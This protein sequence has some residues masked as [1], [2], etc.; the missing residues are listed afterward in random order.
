M[1]EYDSDIEFDFFDEPE[2][3]ES[4]ASPERPRSQRP[5]GGPPARRPPGHAGIP[6][7]AR[8]VG[9][10]AFGILII[11][12]LVLWVQS[13]SGTSRKSSYQRYLGK[14]ALLAADS[15]RFGSSLTQAIATPGIKAGE[16]ANKIDG[17]AQQQ[18][19]DV[20]VAGRLKAP[21]SLARPQ[22]SLLEA[23]RFRVAGL[24][25]LADALR[26]NAGSTNVPS[27]AVT[28]ASE[29]QRLVASDVIWE[30][31]FRRE[32]T[33]LM[34]RQQVTGLAAPSSRFLTDTGVDSTTFWTP[35]LERLNGAGRTG[36]NT[37]GNAV[38]TKLIGVTAQPG[39]KQLSTTT[40]TT[41][42]AGTNL[43]FDVSVQNSGDV[44]VVSV[45][46]TITIQQAPTPI[47]ATRTIALINPGETKTAAFKN[48]PSVNFVPQTKLN[49]DVK[50]VAR[51][52]N[53]NNNSA[54]YP[55]IF[56]LTGP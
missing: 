1:S 47:T 9:L 26:T 41:V 29:T 8:L 24:H 34:T 15:K 23:L 21:S 4:P 39:N 17:L 35:V 31:A 12:L 27:V 10:I 42:N 53:P 52:T 16:L 7:T 18:Q 51:E 50:P 48:L 33:R 22:A 14:V 30:D 45:Q 49:V 54:S 6:P 20:G 2:T 55:V 3:G 36:G 46:V 38:G 28:L 32:T 37:T 11:V 25:G 19:G 44:Q 5:P 43:E 13:C 56:S 40:L